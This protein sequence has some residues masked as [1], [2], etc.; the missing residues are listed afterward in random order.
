MT[1]EQIQTLFE[2]ARS[3]LLSDEQRA[4]LTLINPWSKSGPVAEVMQSEVSR[5]NPAMAKAWIAESGASMSLAAAAAAQGL[6]PVTPELRQEIDR[7]TPVTQEQRNHEQI[8]WLKAQNPYG[9]PGFHREDGSYVPPAPGNLTNAMQL[10]ALAPE[11]AAE[12][13]AKAMPP[14]TEQERFQQSQA[15]AKARSESRLRSVQNTF[16]AR[17]S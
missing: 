12:L 13:K 1:P 15:A 9:T 5:I 11:I 8:E 17:P 14:L 4:R 16:Q 10:E 7:F 6:M 3:P 2:A